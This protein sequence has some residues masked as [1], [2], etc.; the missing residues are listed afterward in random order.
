[1]LVARGNHQ[2]MMVTN[3]VNSLPSM[4]ATSYYGRS[5]YTKHY[6]VKSKLTADLLSIVHCLYPCSVGN[7]EGCPDMKNLEIPPESI[8]GDF[9]CIISK[10]SCKIH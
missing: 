2:S 10:E 5:I 8:L 3:K 6:E 4:V 7:P 9:E 1:M